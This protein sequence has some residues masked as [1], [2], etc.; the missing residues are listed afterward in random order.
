MA[1]NTSVV[2]VCRK[3]Y[4]SR[5]M[6]TRTPDFRMS[7]PEETWC[8]QVWAYEED[9]AGC[10]GPHHVIRMEVDCSGGQSSP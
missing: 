6:W 7:W 5:H 3:F 2:K 9:T 10:Q 8:H 1:G 4:T